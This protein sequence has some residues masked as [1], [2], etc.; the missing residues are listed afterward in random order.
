[1]YWRIFWKWVVV[2][3]ALLGVLALILPQFHVIV[4]ESGQ[5]GKIYLWGGHAAFG[6]S[7][8]GLAYGLALMW[9]L[10]G[11]VFLWLAYFRLKKAD[12]R[13]IA[14]LNWG[15]FFIAVELAFLLGIAE[16]VLSD[17]RVQGLHADSYASWGGAIFLGLLI[18]LLFVPGW[19]KRAYFKKGEGEKGLKA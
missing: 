3:I 9:G 5:E 11:V 8:S 15:A 4:W 7:V 1:M 14:S 12:R 19:V 17:L 10:L 18:G 6:A 13:A 16:E 2:A